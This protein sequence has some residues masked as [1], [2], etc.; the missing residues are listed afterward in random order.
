MVVHDIIVIG[1]GLAGMRAAVEAARSGQNVAIVSKVHPVRSHSVAAQG[2]INAALKQDDPWEDHSFDTVKGSDYLGDQ[3]AIEILTKEAPSDILELEKM[4][5]VFS[6]DETGAIAQRPFG[7]AG[8]PRACYLADRTGHSLLHVL[9][10]QT[11]KHGVFI[12]NE[13]FVLEIVKEGS[14]VSGIIALDMQTGKLHR[15]RAKAVIVA[16]GGY[17]RVF[18][19]TTN[20]LSS[21]GDGMGLALSAGAPLMDMEFVQYHPTTLKRTGLLITEG[22]RGEGGYLINSKGERFMEKYAPSVLELA[23]R[24]VVSRAEQTELNNGLGIDGCIHLDLRH[25]GR[26][27]IMERLPQIR[28]ISIKF[29][30][31]DPILAPIPVRPGAHYS[32]GGVMTDVDGATPVTGLFSAGESACVSVHGA[33]RLGGNSLLETIVF[34]RR[35]GTAASKFSASTD[36]PNFDSTSLARSSEIVGE[37]LNRKDGEKPSKILKDIND[38]M[39]SNC[40]VYREENSLKDGLQKITEIKKRVDRVSLTDKGDVFN[41]ELTSVFELGHILTLAEIIL[42]GAINRKESRGSHSRTDFKERDDKNWLKHTLIKKKNN[43]L[44]IDYKDVTI[45]NFEPKERSY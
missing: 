1:G 42:L 40:S 20:A 26:E 38:V 17:G 2:G 11:I 16:T 44:T 9:F 35:T 10:E 7:G 6:R 36:L 18:G 27:K 25:L 37:L 3:D 45:T 12:Y 24:D 28:E 39:D 43:E 30:G 34:G 4:G 21:T 19:S 29:A 31:V 23:S 41:T 33:N 8:Y 32:M 13:W 5:A 15:L 22:S 14:V